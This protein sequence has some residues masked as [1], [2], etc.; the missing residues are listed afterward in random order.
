MEAR[1]L[2]SDLP[3]DVLTVVDSFK[4][5]RATMRLR[6][7]SDESDFAM[8]V[9]YICHDRYRITPISCERS[10]PR[11]RVPAGLIVTRNGVKRFTIERLRQGGDADYE[12]PFDTLTISLGSTFTLT[13]RYWDK[14]LDR[15][16]ILFQIDLTDP[17]E[18]E[19]VSIRLDSWLDIL[20]E[21][22]V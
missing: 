6:F 13:D 19:R 8:D 10:T 1:D 11:T 9:E 5:Q 21:S 18:I 3:T 20:E 4:E 2:P 7:E 22:Y 16:C 17:V 12:D 15:G 14:D